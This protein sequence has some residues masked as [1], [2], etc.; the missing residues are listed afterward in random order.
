MG[1]VLLASGS[2]KGI[3]LLSQL[4]KVSGY[5]QIT[6]TN[7]GN[8]ARRCIDQTEYE[9]IVINT[10]LS[11]EFGHDFSIKAA[12]SSNSGIILICKSDIADDVS[13]KLSCY[14][15]CV[16]PKPVNKAIFHQSVKLVSATRSRMLGLQ[17]ENFKLQTK[18]EE[19]RLVNRAKC[20]LIQYLKFSE[21]QAHRYIEKQAMDTRQ[22]RKEVA[23]NILSTYE[24]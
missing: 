13:D 6:N 10:P 20:C 11:D 5:S 15:V 9:L 23:L 1:R 12:E 3:E 8:D 18:I 7:S 22:T 19:I 24:Q 2:D 14:G 4:L 21:P 16:I 17:T